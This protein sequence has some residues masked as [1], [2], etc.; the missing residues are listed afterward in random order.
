MTRSN[1][2]PRSHG[3]FLVVAAL[4]L[5]SASA[6]TCNAQ[7]ARF[8][9]NN[10]EY[11]IQIHQRKIVALGNGQA[12][13]QAPADE[14]TQIADFNFDGL[15]DISIPRDFGIERYSDVYLFDTKRGTYRLNK[16]LS[17]LACPSANRESR[18]I[19]S[20][21]N[22]ASACEKWQDTYT[23]KNEVPSLVQRDGT[24]CD[25]ASGKDLKY[26]DIYRNGVVVKSTV[27]EGVE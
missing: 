11:S 22:H 23:F 27:V 9:W 12:I 4:I 16:F 18:T 13:F 15:P 24:S 20:T 6:P 25:P 7:S 19:T 8:S 1:D 21:C 17:S 14:A 10:V 5:L 3:R 2:S 26:I